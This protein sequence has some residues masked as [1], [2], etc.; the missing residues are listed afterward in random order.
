VVQ[1]PRRLRRDV[2]GLATFTGRWQGVSRGAVQI[3]RTE[4][5]VSRAPRDHG[6]A[7]RHYYRERA[8]GDHTGQDR[9][10]ELGGQAR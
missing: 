7:S 10:A 3:A 5:A 2:G 9:G 4:A 6:G 1:T 8:T